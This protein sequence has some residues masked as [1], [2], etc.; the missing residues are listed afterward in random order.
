MLGTALVCNIRA[1]SGE[2]LWGTWELLCARRKLFG[3]GG[4]WEKFHEVTGWVR[5]QH[6]WHDGMARSQID[7][8]L[9]VVGPQTCTFFAIAGAMNQDP[10]ASKLHH[11]LPWAS[12]QLFLA[13]RCCG[14]VC[15]A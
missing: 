6:A 10:E 1:A 8:K 11:T 15:K 4:D 2:T 3:G 14:R 9:T 7:C 5:A 12:F 13:R